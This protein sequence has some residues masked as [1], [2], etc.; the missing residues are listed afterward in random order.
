MRMVAW[1]VWGWLRRL[2][3]VEESQSESL[4]ARQTSARGPV[5]GGRRMEPGP[6]TGRSH[7]EVVRERR[8][9]SAGS[10]AQ[11]AGPAP[12]RTS[13]AGQQGVSPPPDGQAPAEMP[14]A[15]AVGPGK[16]TDRESA[17]RS[18]VGSPRASLTTASGR[19]SAVDLVIG[20]DFGTAATKVVIRSPWLPGQRARAVAF[21][22]LGHRSS[23]YLLPTRLRVASDGHLTLR[24]DVAGEW[25]TDLKV[26]L[27]ERLPPQNGIEDDTIGRAA[28]YLALTLREARARFLT[29]EREIYRR[30]AAQRWA[31]NLGIPSAG[32]DD[33][34]IR[35]RFLRVA[36]AAWWLSEGSEPLTWDSVREAL[37]REPFNPGI[38]IE[39]VPEVAAQ[40]VGYARS[41]LRDPG[42]HLLVD[43]GASTFDVCGF[44][45]H[46]REGQDRYELLTATVD[47]LGVLELHR[48]RLGVL[49]CISGND[50][51]AYDP[52]MPMKQTLDDYHPGCSCNPPDVDAK[53]CDEATGAVMRH[54]IDLKRRRD[55]C[56]RRWETGLPV[57]LCGGGSSMYLFRRLVNEA[58][59]RLRSATTA[60]GLLLRTL[61]KPEHLV[62]DDVGEALFHRLSVAYGLS[63]DAL[64]IGRISP[65]GKIPDIPPPQRRLWEADFISKDQV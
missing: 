37:R 39:V 16:R 44:V 54:L 32:Y 60:Q 64:D 29:A 17:G 20:L 43:V 58:D 48:R 3:R 12:T 51:M 18:V 59:A 52:L 40:A 2:F 27:L 45:L 53:F 62:N 61:P 47:R 57:F 65:P 41:T 22:E 56:S 21:G 7:R 35:R 38:A 19:V 11:P 34:L 5:A 26:R 9:P 8:V 28:A 36:R 30:F 25:V 31:L 24:G 50:P 63:F 46:E 6:S 4:A 49:Q 1:R 23:P 10:E 42:L 33:E 13:S 14:R 55:P 15:V